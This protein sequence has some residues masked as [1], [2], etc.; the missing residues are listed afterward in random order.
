MLA[1]LGWALFLAGTLLLLSGWRDVAANLFPVDYQT[2]IHSAR[3]ERKAKAARRR[4]DFRCQ[5]CGSG[6]WP[7]EVH[8]KTY[9][10]LGYE[11]AGDLVVV[12]NQC[13]RRRHGN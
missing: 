4:A 6:D 7:L 13:H 12:C 11:P 5:D 8:H 10:R 3:W 9:A 2:Y 1:A